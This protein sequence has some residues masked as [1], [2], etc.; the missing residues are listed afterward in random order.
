LFICSTSTLVKSTD[1]ASFCPLVN[2]ELI[3][4]IWVG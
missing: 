3:I 4:K 1:F 2:G